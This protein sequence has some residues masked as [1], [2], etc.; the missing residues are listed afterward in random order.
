MAPGS[1]W[2][3]RRLMPA[4]A[5]LGVRDMV[6]LT[7]SQHQIAALEGVAIAGERRID[8]VG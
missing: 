8:P 2:E 7:N 3:A 1:I 6:L 5:D 4:V